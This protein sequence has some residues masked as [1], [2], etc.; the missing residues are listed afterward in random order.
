MLVILNPTI[1]FYLLAEAGSPM[2]ASNGE[3]F[4]KFIPRELAPRYMI[5]KV[6]GCTKKCTGLKQRF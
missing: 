5:D 3:M 2:I 4:S 6:K 1:G